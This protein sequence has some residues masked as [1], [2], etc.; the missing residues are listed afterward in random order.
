MTAT[1]Y[2]L[3]FVL[4]LCAARPLYAA[5]LVVTIDPSKTHQKIDG[6]G[7]SGAWWAQGVGGW[8]K[9][10]RDRILDLLFTEKGADLSIYR[11]NIGAGLQRD[12]PYPWRKTETFEVAPGKYDWA[13]DASAVRIMRE[14]RQ[15]GVDRFV[16]FANSPPDR[17]TVSGASSGGREGGSNLKPE[18]YQAFANYCIDIAEHWRK[19]LK[20]DKAILSPINE[21]QW[22]WG[23][24]HRN[25]E[26]CHYTPEE[27]VEALRVV[28]REIKSRK[29][30]MLLEG[31]EA[32]Q[33][34]DT[35]VAYVQAILNDAEVSGALHHLAV[36][37]YFSDNAQRKQLRALVDRLKPE[38]PIAMTE[39]CQM[40]GGRDT[41]M[42]SA[43][44]LATV[45]HEDLT[46]GRVV[47][48]Q[49]WIAVSPYNFRDGLIY[50][51]RRSQQIIET[52]RLWVM[53]NFS[54]FVRPGDQR[55]VCDD[56]SMWLGTVAFRSADGK[57]IACV[58]IN[59]AAKPK[60]VRIDAPNSVPSRAYTTSAE[61]DLKARE[62]EGGTLLL[63]PRSVTTVVLVKDD[64]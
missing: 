60:T 44:A 38:L 1:H 59:H 47:S 63:P 52:K 13:K 56:N 8:P 46:L 4:C 54:R 55:I 5:E 24:D 53:A 31:P 9:E 16:F 36:H 45:M 22:N 20:L 10:K 27:T 2:L 42:D 37:A 50:I 17:L 64:G 14:V 29:A 32:G 12:T 28:A 61:M 43:M 62:V 49:K 30:P 23:R 19:D 35:T 15:R 6:F 40:R 21:P 41:G 25:Q 39:W 33:W 7:A 51:N 26:G 48:W 11:Y 57:R 3:L 34:G 18:N 58:V